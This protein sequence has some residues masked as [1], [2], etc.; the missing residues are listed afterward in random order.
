MYITQNFLA[1]SGWPEMRVLLH[2]N[3]ITSVERTNS[4]IFIA[5]AVLITTYEGIEYSFGSFVDRDHCY[6]ILHSMVEVFK[7]LR[8]IA[9]GKP[10][11]V[12][13]PK[14]L[15]TTVSPNT[16]LEKS[17]SPEASMEHIEIP[18]AA[19]SPP[20]ASSSS[21]NDTQLLPNTVPVHAPVAAVVPLVDMKALFKRHDI[22]ILHEQTLPHSI[23]K[24]YMSC[25]ESCKGYW[26]FLSAQ[27]ELQID[28]TDWVVPPVKTVTEDPTK[29]SFESSRKVSYLHPR[30]DVMTVFG[31]KNAPTA[32][33][34]Y[35]HKLGDFSSD[36][37]SFLVTTITQ[38][39]G[40]PMADMFKIVQYWSFQYKSETE[41]TL[42]V[43]VHV[44]FIKSTMFKSQ[45][46]GNVREE[47]TV[48]AKKWAKF[49]DQ[50]AAIFVPSVTEVV[51]ATVS[52][53]PEIL[54]QQSSA[55]SSISS[56]AKVPSVSNLIQEPPQST[57]TTEPAIGAASQSSYTKLVFISVA[58]VMGIC[59]YVLASTN[60]GLSS[61]YQK[62]EASFQD[63]SSK[64]NAKVADD[65][66]FQSELREF[67]KQ[68]LSQVEREENVYAKEEQD[69]DEPQDDEL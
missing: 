24:I 69:E 35:L 30:A 37:R 32:Q 51:S 2:M 52:E 58:V 41:V 29:T 39:D 18:L 14:S 11:S 68:Q 65:A 45:V 49:A 67:M 16:V 20:S 62:L 15:S 31:P 8:E 61:K 21:V 1:F 33:T 12:P 22:A 54:L 6:T 4:V 63:L 46:V 47:L 66:V 26:D 5:N 13:S 42:L 55:A 9:S 48:M 50:R 23:F 60:Y 38:F 10:L 3:Q 19:L 56:V 25:W 57:G 53:P 27:G 28:C 34:H 40:I 7:S 59:I 64:F 44:H 43:G 36:P 17:R